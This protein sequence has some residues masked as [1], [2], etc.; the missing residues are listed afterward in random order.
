MQL[1][2]ISKREIFFK[3]GEILICVFNHTASTE[4][5][6]DAT[7]GSE[8]LDEQ[9]EKMGLRE[10]SWLEKAMSNLSYMRITL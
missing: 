8:R 1:T 5:V 7:G 2:H 6:Y 10:A 3:G 4:R 9:K